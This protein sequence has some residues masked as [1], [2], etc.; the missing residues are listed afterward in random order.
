M[1]W[2]WTYFWAFVAVVNGLGY[3]AVRSGMKVA[4]AE[5]NRCWEMNKELRYESELV[6]SEN[7]TLRRQIRGTTVSTKD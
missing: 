5:V 7:L 1:S 6:R 3:F 4:M 2:N